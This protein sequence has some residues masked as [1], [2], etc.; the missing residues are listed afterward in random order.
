MVGFCTTAAAALRTGE[1]AV[2]RLFENGGPL[3]GRE[4]DLAR[5][6]AFLCGPVRAGAPLLLLGEPGVGKT[7]LLASAA[8]RAAERGVRVVAA[9]GM[10][11]EAH[12]S[13][14]GLGRLLAAPATRRPSLVLDNALA[15]ALGR[16]HGPA[17]EPEAVVA[18][19][20]ALLRQVADDTPALLAVDDVHCLDPA[21]ALVRP[22]PG[23]RPG[24]GR[25]RATPGRHRRP[26]AVYGPPCRG[27]LLRPQRA[28]RAGRG[29][30][31]RR[32]GRGPARPA[33]PGPRRA[34]TP[35]SDG[36]GAGKPSGAAGTSR[37]AQQPAAG[38]CGSPARP[39][40]AEPPPPVRVRIPH[41]RP[42]RGNPPPAPAGCLGRHRRLA[43]TAARGGRAVQHQAPGGRRTRP[44]PRRS[45]VHRR[46]I[47]V[48]NRR[49]G[50]PW[51]HW[52]RCAAPSDSATG[53]RNR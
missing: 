6:D 23:Q 19:V 50:M 4:A 51:R 7:A 25:G 15:V 38:R 10:E 3:V 44:Q 33:L 37:R 2:P 47:P 45:R 24:P 1:R 28:S 22:G 14:S 48:G 26:H 49:C 52:R 36:R 21:S 9:A 5:I 41:H 11:Y 42:A 53:T 20:P 16:E 12:L 31:R 39:P 35:P 43:R 8:S 40:S 30:A 13:Y 27:Q 34:G 17:P 18:A 32:L 46:A 29:P